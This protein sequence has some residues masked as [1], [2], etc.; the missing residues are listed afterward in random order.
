MHGIIKLIKLL[1]I[2]PIAS[3]DILKKF[4]NYLE[5][6][7]NCDGNWDNITDKGLLELFDTLIELGFGKKQENNNG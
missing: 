4:K 5:Y 7:N 3:R 2:V 1:N 6:N